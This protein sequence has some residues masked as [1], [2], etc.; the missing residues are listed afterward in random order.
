[1]KRVSGR[2]AAVLIIVAIVA[3]LTMILHKAKREKAAAPAWRPRPAPVETADVIEGELSRT[4]RY[5]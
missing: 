5:L 2:I 4:L 1:M 3:G